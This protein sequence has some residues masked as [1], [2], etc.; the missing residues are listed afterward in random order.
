MEDPI[1]RRARIRK[2]WAQSPQGRASRKVSEGKRRA[3][4][5]GASKITVEKV[6]RVYEKNIKKYGT[7]TCELCFEKIRL[8]EDSLEHFVPISRH[9]EFPDLDLN[10]VDNLGVAHDGFSSREKC[11]LRK[12]YMTLEE[13]F[14]KYPEYLVKNHFEGRRA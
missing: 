5:E 10:C 12:W 4:L 8:G 14:R 7:L 9:F 1:L 13:W 2:L 3:N 6:Q 11:N